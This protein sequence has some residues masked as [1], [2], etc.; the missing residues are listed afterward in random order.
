[1]LMQNERILSVNEL[2]KPGY[3]TT[4]WSVKIKK[5]DLNWEDT[6]KLD[7]VSTVQEAHFAAIIIGNI[8]SKHPAQ[9]HKGEMLQTTTVERQIHRYLTV[10]YYYPYPC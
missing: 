6:E 8:C 7:G 3:A 1:M 4:T 5:N 9:A 10:Y 2:D